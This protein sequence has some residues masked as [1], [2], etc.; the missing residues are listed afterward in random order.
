MR[1]WTVGHSTLP[2]GDFIDLLRLHGIRLLADVRRFPSSRRHPHF[3]RDSLQAALDDA[4]IGYRHY[5]ALGGRREPRA[6]SANNGWREAGFRGYA[7]HMQ[8]VEFQ[9][10]LKHLLEAASSGPTAIMCAEKAWQNCHRGLISDR[11]KV[12]GHEVIHIIDGMRQEQHPYTRPARI[13]DGALSYAAPV[14]VQ[15]SL[16]L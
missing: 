11:L 12:S 10:S 9:T 5:P 3:N 4:G 2:A 1:I 6:D 13:V 15:S 14:S 8:T 16:D 7:D